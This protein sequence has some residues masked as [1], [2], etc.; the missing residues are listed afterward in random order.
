MAPEHPRESIGPPNLT[1]EREYDASP[2]E[3][4]QAWT[5]PQALIRWFGPEQTEA[6]LQAELD[7]RVGGCYHIA[8][9]TR[10]GERHDVS[11]TYREVEPQRSLVFTWAWRTTPE[12]KSLVRVLLEPAG[13]GTRLIF[14]HEQFFDEVARDNHR[15]GWTGTF[16]K[17]ARYLQGDL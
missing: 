2:E 14:R 4:W 5:D 9:T 13:G 1:I 15:G 8:F 12:R 10:D 6:V 3:V 17:L 7:V 11:G 16:H